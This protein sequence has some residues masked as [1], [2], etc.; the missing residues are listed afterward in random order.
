MH[1]WPST[2]G[3]ALSRCSFTYPPVGGLGCLSSP[4]F[5]L[6]CAPYKGSSTALIRRGRWPAVIPDHPSQFNEAINYYPA[7]SAA[8]GCTFLC[9]F[10]RLF[11]FHNLRMERGIPKTW[12]PVL[13]QNYLLVDQWQVI[14]FSVLK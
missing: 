7:I 14:S 11:L 10:L 6:C 1:R 2:Q 9:V 3:L 12:I 4:G 13:T 8:L 5:S